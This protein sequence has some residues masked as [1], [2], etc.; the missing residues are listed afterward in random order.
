[1]GSNHT[2]KP[3]P[4]PEGNGPVPP[5]G[6]AGIKRASR[7]SILLLGFVLLKSVL[8]FLL[9][10]AI[11]GEFGAGVE[12]DAYFAAFTIPQQLGDFVIGGILFK[13]LIPVFQ[14]RRKAAGTERAAEE[15][16]GVLNFSLA[17]LLILT[18]FFYVFAPVAVPALFPG[19][20]PSA[21]QLATKLT[22]YLSPA[23]VLMGLSIIYTGLHHS[24]KSFLV[25]AI[26][27]IILPSTSMAAIFFLPREWGIERLAYGNLAGMTAGLI[28][29]IAL[30][31][32]EFRWRWRWSMDN[33]ALKTSIAMAWP[34]LLAQLFG[35]I[36]PFVQK[37]AASKL[38]QGSVSLLEYAFFL[39]GA[40]TV[41]VVAPISTTILP[42]MGEHKAGDDE[43]SLNSTFHQTIGVV[44]FLSLPCVI[45]LALEAHDI[46]SLLF[47]VGKFSS[48]DVVVCSSLLAVISLMI[49]PQALNT[50]IGNMFL[51]HKTTKAIALAGVV[52]TAL[53]V[54]VYFIMA[55]RYGVRGIA[56]TYTGY[57]ALSP[58]VGIA[59]LQR[60][61]RGIIASG[62]VLASAKF[63]AAAT[64][65]ALCAWRVGSLVENAN[66][67]VKMAAT[68]T[69]VA[70]PYLLA[71][72][73]L[74][75]K[76][77]PFLLSRFIPG[78]PGHPSN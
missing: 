44:V 12:T 56:I 61:R 63:I 51:V 70:I 28:L 45:L 57:Y 67:I 42:V 17:I 15:I 16:S 60:G 49:V 4:T 27:T 53:V 2:A 62:T 72:A 31:R 69:A 52:M 47:G 9:K 11:A 41:F 10:R 43:A 19:F 77:L 58:V 46:V 36:V 76:A 8:G 29:L 13:I 25:P 66:P 23:I 32:G 18:A 1:M 38:S 7:A 21:E 59:L 30:L 74:K 35:K 71:A 6:L 73:L 48:A 26:S 20:N 5:P 14:E 34:L 33:P 65:A 55:N 68:A 78:V 24:F 3:G 50:V 22:R 54:P 40:V 75:I 37:S 39:S 64:I